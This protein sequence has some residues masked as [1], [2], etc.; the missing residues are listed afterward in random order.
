MSDTVKINGVIFSDVEYIQVPK[1]VQ[2][3]EGEPEPEP[4]YVY[5]RHTRNLTSPIN[6]AEVFAGTA[7]EIND[8]NGEING[9]LSTRV[10]NNNG[11]IQYLH[12]PAVTALS[13][14]GACRGCGN[15][16]YV[17]MDSCVTGVYRGFRE[18][19]R[20]EEA[21]FPS[22]TGVNDEMFYSCG[23]LVTCNFPEV[24]WVGSSSFNY[25]SR[26][27]SISLPKC[28]ILYNGAFANCPLLETLEI[29]NVVTI[30]GADVFSGCAKLLNFTFE[31]VTSFSSDYT[32]RGSRF[33]DVSFPSYASAVRYRAFRDAGGCRIIRFPLGTGADTEAFYNSNGITEVYI[34]KATWIGGTNTFYNCASLQKLVL[35][36]YF[37]TL[38]N[39]NVFNGSSVANGTGFVYV[40]L[41]FLDKIRAASNWVGYAAQIKPFEMLED[42][43]AI[44][45]NVSLTLPSGCN[46]IVHYE[47]SKCDIR[48]TGNKTIVG[49]ATD[50]LNY[51]VECA[52]FVSTSGTVAL[53]DA[54]PNVSIDLSGLQADANFNGFSITNLDF[55]E[56]PVN[57]S[58]YMTMTS[59]GFSQYGYENYYDKGGIGG[60]SSSNYLNQTIT[61]PDYSG[62]TNPVFLWEAITNIDALNGGGTFYSMG[63]SNTN[64]GIISAGISNVSHYANG[65][66]F[67][68]TGLKLEG[69]HHIAMAVTPTT[70]YLYVD[71][72][73]INSF[74]D[75]Y[76]INGMRYATPRIGNNQSSS[77]EYYHGKIS[78][79]AVTIRDIADPS[80]YEN[81]GF[82][83]D[84]LVPQPEVEE[85]S[86]EQ[87]GE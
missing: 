4:E 5:Y 9:V 63:G 69:M 37:A 67:N 12:L 61:L 3:F 51:E 36:H 79:L 13:G 55:M 59:N 19:G 82:M 45:Y 21:D 23:N 46:P 28:T 25:C 73:F 41:Y 10:T 43:T 64:N 47:T 22:L 44:E 18:C 2:P 30:S 56:W 85:E 34:G 50:T 42:D 66:R 60:F 40:D 74:A 86:G 7:T 57:R 24:T 71:G 72:E 35:G 39:T 38:G 65:S 83:L 68:A 70:V 1:F 6:I 29:P 8:F 87:V 49:G 77:G 54:D 81:C 14:E 20:L 58:N 48:A 62:M 26:L 78:N 11:A 53:S 16:R 84:G 32:F 76:M 75:T 31:K 17:K 52:G 33:A 80:V 15:L 27:A